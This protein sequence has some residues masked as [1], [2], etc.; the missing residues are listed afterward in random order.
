MKKGHKEFIRNNKLM[1]KTQRKFKSET[2]KIF[3]E[4]INDIA[5]NSNDDKIVQPIETYAFAISKELVSEK[6]EIKCNNI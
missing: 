5:L 6:E 4:D 1:L 3:T 2:H